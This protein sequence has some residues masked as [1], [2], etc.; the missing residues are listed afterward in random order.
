MVKGICKTSLN[1]TFNVELKNDRLVWEQHSHPY[2]T[3]TKTC[4]D[5]KIYGYPI[6]P[7]C[8]FTMGSIL[9]QYF[10]TREPEFWRFNC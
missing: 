3:D 6:K 2:I 4:S 9:S 10:D 5:L 8:L 1:N 7:F